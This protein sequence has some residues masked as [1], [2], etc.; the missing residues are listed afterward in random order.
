MRSRTSAARMNPNVY[1]RP[2]LFG[3]A[4]VRYSGLP[5]G[6][7]V[8]PATFDF[9]FDFYEQSVVVPTYDVRGESFVAARMDEKCIIP[10]AQNPVTPGPPS[11]L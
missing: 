2:R 1:S 7:G 6:Q 3:A 8:Q 4:S 11:K 9:L 10:S 5:L